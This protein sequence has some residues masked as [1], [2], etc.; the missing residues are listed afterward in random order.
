MPQGFFYFADPFLDTKGIGKRWHLSTATK[1]G[2]DE[3]IAKYN[4]QLSCYLAVFCEMQ[5]GISMPL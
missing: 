2:T 3:S 5:H 1:D 4:G